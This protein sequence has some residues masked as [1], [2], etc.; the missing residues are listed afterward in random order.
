ML[1]W[2]QQAPALSRHQAKLTS[3]PG[4]RNSLIRQT[5]S[6]CL[7]FTGTKARSAL[8]GL[9]VLPLQMRA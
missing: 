2:G 3:P 4:K 5:V 8:N 9:K 6:K 1:W 7:M